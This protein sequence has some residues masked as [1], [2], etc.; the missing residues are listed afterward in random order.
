MMPE[1]MKLV[2]PPMSHTTFN[3][4]SS[5]TLGG[6]SGASGDDN[7]DKMSQYKYRR[8]QNAVAMR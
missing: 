1:L 6:S 3:T 5:V 4:F 8:V 7:L 2:F